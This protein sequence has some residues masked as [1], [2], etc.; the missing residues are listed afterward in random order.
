MMPSCKACR[1][2]ALPQY[3]C[4]CTCR[5]LQ[6]KNE[7]ST[8]RRT[9]RRPRTEADEMADVVSTPEP[10]QPRN[11]SFQD[12]VTIPSLRANQVSL[13]STIFQT[14]VTKCRGWC[15]PGPPSSQHTLRVL[16]FF[17]NDLRALQGQPKFAENSFF[18]TLG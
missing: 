18:I 4:H 17:P 16:I 13:Q 10:S 7:S 5:N 12:A 9:T 1:I 3:A 6:R 2:R 14:Q 8:S 11:I 15:R